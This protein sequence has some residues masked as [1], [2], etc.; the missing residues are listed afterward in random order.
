MLRACEQLG[1]DFFVMECTLE[2]GIS[3]TDESSFWRTFGNKF[4]TTWP[5]LPPIS[6]A[7]GFRAWFSPSN[8]DTFFG[9]KRVVLFIDE[10]DLLYSAPPVCDSVLHAL[11]GLKQSHAKTCL[12]SVVTVGPF[13]ILKLTSRTG[14]PFN[15]AD[16]VVSPPFNLEQ[17]QRL[18]AQLEAARGCKLDADIALDVHERTDGHTGLVGFC[19]KMLDEVLLRRGGGTQMVSSNEW[20]QF[21]LRDLVGEL[22]RWPTMR[23]M[24]DTLSGHV[25]VNERLAAA[26]RDFLCDRL[27]PWPGSVRLETEDELQLAEFLTA[28]GAT[29]ERSARQFDISCDLVR[30][31][32]LAQ[33]VPLRLRQPPLLAFPFHDGSMDVHTFL[34]GA[35]SSFDA[36]TIMD[37]R[38]FAFKK[39]PSGAGGPTGRLVPHEWTYH[40]ELVA[41]LRAW[42]PPGV[43]YAIELKHGLPGRQR[44]DVELS[45]GGKRVLLEL[46]ATGT[47]AQVVEHYNRAAASQLAVDADEVFVVHFVAGDT[48]HFPLPPNGVRAVHF[49]HDG[50]F[51]NVVMLTPNEANSSW[52]ALDVP[53][54]ERRP[55]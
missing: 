45:S 5:Q 37:A 8:R 3:F 6:D 46:M 55:I 42:A 13:S 15:V 18:F 28:E 32:L 48:R 34:K 10:F 30:A 21:A 1:Q 41:V 47:D 40:F 29:A 52:E 50:G 7:D 36:H 14:S 26:A 9:G 19:G 24:I 2:D 17:V 39:T 4:V 23:K 31:L 54:A 44:C 43:N 35:V 22:R 53:L 16:S 11:R 51:E 12:H 33:V 27:L 38:R 20:L 25:G 49:C